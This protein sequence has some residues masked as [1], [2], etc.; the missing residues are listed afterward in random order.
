MR[1]LRLAQYSYLLSPIE[2]YWSCF[3]AEVKKNLRNVMPELLSYRRTGQGLTIWEFRMRKLETISEMASQK[4]TSQQLSSF[5]NH[6]ERY[7]A[8][9]LRGDDL[10]ENPKV[11]KFS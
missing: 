6:V 3:K 11:W 2:L 7:Y 4:V 1:I 5:A 8:G 9:V 10:A